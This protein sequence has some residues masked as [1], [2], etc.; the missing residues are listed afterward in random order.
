MRLLRD[1]G[2]KAV[3]GMPAM[4]TA[5][6]LAIPAGCTTNLR[7]LLD[8]HVRAGEAWMHSGMDGLRGL[9]PAPAISS[10]AAVSVLVEAVVDETALN[11]DG[12]RASEIIG[13]GDEHGRRQRCRKERRE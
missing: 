10:L 4:C 11:S 1:E 7:M 8:V 6:Q 3:G 12:K 2:V 5:V 9:H 13:W